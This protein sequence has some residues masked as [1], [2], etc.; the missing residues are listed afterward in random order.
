ML[1]SLHGLQNF[2]LQN[3]K[4]WINHQLILFWFA[5]SL[6]YFNKGESTLW[7]GKKCCHIVPF[8]KGV[9]IWASTMVILEHIFPNFLHNMID[10]NI[11]N[12]ITKKIHFS[13]LYCEVPKYICGKKKYILYS[14]RWKYIK[15]WL[16]WFLVFMKFVVSINIVIPYDWNKFVS[17]MKNLIIIISQMGAFGGYGHKY[18]VN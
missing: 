17:H 14:L 18:V 9:H 8:S 16:K 13:N 10:Y 3:R 5:H 6:H 1:C 2:N 4:R 12:S 11:K 7:R 15:K